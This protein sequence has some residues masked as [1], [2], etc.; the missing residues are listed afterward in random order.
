MNSSY[1]HGNVD[2]T[3]LFLCH[4]LHGR[5]VFSCFMTQGKH[6]TSEEGPSQEIEGDNKEL[7]SE[8]QRER[9][10]LI[11]SAWHEVRLAQHGLI[12]RCL[13]LSQLLVK[14]KP[15]KLQKHWHPK[16]TQAGNF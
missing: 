16:Q 13:L 14:R 6:R 9:P 12:V 4:H 2:A 8:N 11:E 1:F 15:Q 3:N 7:S 5:S 10:I